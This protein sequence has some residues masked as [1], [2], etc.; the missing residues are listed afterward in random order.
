M[1]SATV[2]RDRGGFLLPVVLLLLVAASG[3]AVVALQ[4]ARVE[5]MTERW[6][7]H[8][9][10]ERLR[11]ERTLSGE[12]APDVEVRSL[13]GG[14]VLIRG[15]AGAAPAPAGVVWFLDPDSVAASLPPAAEVG[16]GTP[17]S[18]IVGGDESCGPPPTEPWVRVR[19][20]TAA[21]GPDPP[22]QPPP[23]LGPV[24]VPALLDRAEVG[25]SPGDPLPGAPAPAVI[26]VLPDSRITSGEGGGVLVTE[27]SLVLAG[28]A[29][30]RGLVLVQGA[31]TL[32]EEAR[33][34]GVV[35][36][37]ERLRLQDGAILVGCRASAQAALRAPALADPFRANAGRL[38][39]RF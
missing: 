32:E 16:W 12:P 20:A 36:V 18:G 38:L 25:L 19:E 7:A 17:G 30:W 3:L 10:R 14:F 21:P 1:I 35:L 13:R 28:D 8:H 9:L 31:L 27:G 4:A 24:G 11:W 26:A 23:R 15:R 34:E 33:V 6:D 37:G 29:R 39:G 2:I 5:V 22:L